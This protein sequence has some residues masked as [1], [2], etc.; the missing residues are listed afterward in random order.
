MFDVPRKLVGTVQSLQIK[1][2]V[3]DY[4]QG[5]KRLFNGSAWTHT[6]FG[7]PQV[8]DHETHTYADSPSQHLHKSLHLHLITYMLSM[9]K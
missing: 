4:R 5:N 8:Q 2:L 3:T 6:D 9:L 7:V 1:I